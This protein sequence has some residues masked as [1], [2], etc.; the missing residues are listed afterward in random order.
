MH[1]ISTYFKHL[2]Y[3]EFPYNALIKYKN[4]EFLIAYNELIAGV[5]AKHI[6]IIKQTH[7]KVINMIITNITYNKLLFI[8]LYG[9]YHSFT[10]LQS[11]LNKCN[12]VTFSDGKLRLIYINDETGVLEISNSYT[13]KYGEIFKAYTHDYN[14]LYAIVDKNFDIYGD[15]KPDGSNY[16]FGNKIIKVE[17]KYIIPKLLALLNI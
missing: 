14:A 12:H 1:R 6:P 15:T 3:T 13:Y 16:V 5:I 10:V 4:H 17:S 8:D 9:N 2:D 7:F 11:M